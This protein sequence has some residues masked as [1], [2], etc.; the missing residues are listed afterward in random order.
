[1]D[2]KGFLPAHMQTKMTGGS[3]LTHPLAHAGEDLSRTGTAES[4]LATTQGQDKLT[5]GTG[6]DTSATAGSGMGGEAAKN[7]GITTDSRAEDIAGAR[8]DYEA[9]RRAPAATRETYPPQAAAAHHDPYQKDTQQSGYGR[10]TTKAANELYDKRD[11]QPTQAGTG[12]AIAV[13]DPYAKNSKQGEYGRDTTQAANEIYNQR[14]T[15]P[16]QAATGAAM[17]AAD[18]YASHSQRGTHGR[19]T[20]QAA[21]ELYDNQRA[22]PPAQS[23]TGLETHDPYNAARQAGAL[24]NRDDIAEIDR[25]TEMAGLGAGTGAGAA[26]GMGAGAIASSGRGYE[27]PTHAAG[28]SV[29]PS[30]GDRRYQQ[31]TGEGYGSGAAPF[32]EGN[33]DTGFTAGGEPGLGRG[34]AGRDVAE[35]PGSGAGVGAGMAQRELS[36]MSGS[37][38]GAGAGAGS[39]MSGVSGYDQSSGA[40]IGQAVPM[41]SSGT[42]AA[43][44][45]DKAT[46]GVGGPGGLIHGH[47]STITG[48]RLDP[49]L[50]Q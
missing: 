7:R 19:D 36:E 20:T 12:A 42:S 3:S 30:T 16:T 37:G 28:S 11:K 15:K 27:Q 31:S 1:M 2:P 34:M 48:E 46:D 23:A 18:P 43:T 21:N 25:E 6:R 40:P 4:P 41:T 38:V 8:Q 39:G 49:H 26:A 33:P 13:E 10:D 44:G 47:H 17:S 9:D 50:G 24:L 5:S 29:D 32:I 45:F 14:D 35:M 22:A